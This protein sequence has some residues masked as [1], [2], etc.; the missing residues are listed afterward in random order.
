[1][2][3]SLPRTPRSAGLALIVLGEVFLALA[4]G[5]GA[6][7]W[8]R[9]PSPAPGEGELLPAVMAIDGG[10]RVYAVDATADGRS[11]I[12]ATATTGVFLR[13]PRCG[14]DEAI[15]QGVSAATLELGVAHFPT[16]AL[17]GADGNCALAAHGASGL[18][19]GA[20]FERL[21]QLKPGDPVFL[22]DGTG[23]SVGYVVTSCRVVNE[24]DLNVLRP[25]SDRRLTLITCVVP[26]RITHQRL[27][28]TAVA[29][30]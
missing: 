3:L 8:L 20:P 18:R 12:P 30:P 23:R 1:V 2:R 11:A 15:H 7:T 13:I 17:P 29:A 5:L 27:V 14:I 25:T 19:H 6:Y 4:L 21:A 9:P 22:H 16:T 24:H 28:V 26:S 10:T